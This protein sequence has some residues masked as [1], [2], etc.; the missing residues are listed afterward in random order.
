MTRLILIRHG[1]SMG[2]AKRVF[3]GHTDWDI[4]EKGIQGCSMRDWIR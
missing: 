3:L 4:T 2:N 1:E